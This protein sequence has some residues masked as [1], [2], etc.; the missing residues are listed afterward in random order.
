MN[1]EREIAEHVQ[2][3]MFPSEIEI[4]KE[5]TGN[6]STKDALRIAILFTNKNYRAVMKKQAKKE[7]KEIT[8]VI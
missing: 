5:V 8:E 2:T 1:K 6:T 3:T 7:I 4:L